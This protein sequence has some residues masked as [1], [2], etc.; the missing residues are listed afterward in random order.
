M[1]QQWLAQ[2]SDVVFGGDSEPARSPVIVAN[3]SMD[4]EFQGMIRD[5][6]RSGGWRP[7]DLE[8]YLRTRYPHA[9]VRPRELTGESVR[10]WYVYRD[11]HWIGSERSART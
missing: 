6:L 5:A 4:S 2:V 7:E 8:A 3:P 9:I 1:P 10:V 11:G